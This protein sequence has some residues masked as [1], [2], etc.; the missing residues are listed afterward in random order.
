[1]AHAI[2]TSH[3]GFDLTGRLRRSIENFRQARACRMA[4]FQVF[5]ELDRLSD[6]DLADLGIGRSDITEIARIHAYGA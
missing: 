4:Y 6:R 5:N 2:R 3:T 1:M